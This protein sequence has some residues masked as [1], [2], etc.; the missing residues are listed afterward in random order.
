MTKHFWLGVCGGLA[1]AALV[2]GPASAQNKDEF[3]CQQ[4]T[5]KVGAKFILKKTKCVQKCEKNA[6]KGKNSFDDCEP[7]YA[8]DTLACVQKEEDKAVSGVIKACTKG[9]PICYGGGGACDT[10]ADDLVNDPGTGLEAQLDVFV[11]LVVCDPDSEAGNKDVEKCID[12]TGKEL[13]KFVGKK[14]KCYDKCVNL[15]FKGKIP[16][17]SC[18]FGSPSDQKTLDCIAKAETKAEANI[19][20]KCGDVG[21]APSCWLFS[22]GAGWVG[23]TESAVDDQ[24]PSTYCGSPSGAFLS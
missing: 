9:C 6:R 13:S 16:G 4:K 15:E 10:F 23:L 18:T 12:T 2:A 19:D 5:S 8:N 7:P 22:T 3:K 11:P 17:G 21:A 1:V 24:L 14:T 20:K